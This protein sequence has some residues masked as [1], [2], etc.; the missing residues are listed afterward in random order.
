MLP[1]GWEIERQI[2]EQLPV[3]QRHRRRGKCWTVVVDDRD[4]GVDDGDAWVPIGEHGE[5]V[6]ARRRRIVGV[7]IE[8]RRDVRRWDNDV[9][10]GRGEIAVG[11]TVVVFT[12]CRNRCHRRQR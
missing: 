7:E 2:V 6:C 8:H 5:I 12:R 10:V 11:G 1:G 4:I 3:G 9:H